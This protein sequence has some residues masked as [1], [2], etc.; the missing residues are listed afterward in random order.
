MSIIKFL[1][2]TE[3]TEKLL[4]SNGCREEAGEW[5]IWV[6]DANGGYQRNLPIDLPIP[7][8]Y[9]SEQMLSWSH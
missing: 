5:A 7:Y 8:T 4:K 9:V 3:F 6:M 2:G 1:Y